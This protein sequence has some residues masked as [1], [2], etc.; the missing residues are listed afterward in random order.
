MR[1]VQSASAAALVIGLAGACSAQQAGYRDLT[2]SWRA[3]DDHIPSPSSETCPNAQSTVSDGDHPQTPATA[4][5]QDD[6]LEL[7]ITEVVPSDLHLGDDF[8]ATV[9]LKNIGTT[10][11]LIPWQPDGEQ[12][13]RVSKD[14]KQEIYEVADVAF[15]LKTG[16]QKRVPMFLDSEGA[17]FAHPDDHATYLELEPGRWAD[18]KLKGS[19]ICG[20]PPCPVEAEADDHAVL[21]AWWYQRVLTHRVDGCN[22]NHGAST[23]RKL[24]SSPF[25]L[26]IHAPATLSQGRIPY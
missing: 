23:V 4:G 25:P 5:K 21:T 8:T 20:L 2:I 15:R 3:P 1:L 24:D 10:K 12:V 19:V 18:I 7:T 22:E 26:A 17:L 13:T 9:R 6:K 11:V 16:G 14:G